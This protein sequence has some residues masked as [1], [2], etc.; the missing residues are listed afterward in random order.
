MK[1]KLDDVNWYP[2][3]GGAVCDDVYSKKAGEVVLEVG[4]SGSSG[5]R[6][7]AQASDFWQRRSGS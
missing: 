7:Y 3:G 1:I 2:A 5:S 4:P 6:F